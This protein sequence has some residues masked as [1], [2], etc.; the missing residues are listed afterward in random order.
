MN[1]TRRYAIQE[2][3]VCAIAFLCDHICVDHFEAA[4]SKMKSFFSIFHFLSDLQVVFSL[5]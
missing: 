1:S 2:N 4:L 3:D 5:S